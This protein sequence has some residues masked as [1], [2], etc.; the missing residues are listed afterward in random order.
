MSKS[1]NTTKPSKKKKGKT[2]RDDTVID[3][4]EPMARD[5]FDNL[6]DE[7]GLIFA[8]TEDFMKPREVLSPAEKRWREA[9]GNDSWIDEL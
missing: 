5:A 1:K 4:L 6:M 8:D 3:L 2:G 9:T 7:L